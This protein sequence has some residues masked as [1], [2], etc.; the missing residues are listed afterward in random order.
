MA[1]ERQDEWIVVTEDA[2]TIPVIEVLTGR[3]FVTGKSGSG[4]SVLEGTI[5]YTEN[6]RK[7]IED[8]EKGERVLSLNKHDYQNEFRE[9]L[10]TI[11]HESDR[12]LRLT[13]EDGTELVGTE[14]HSFL[15]IE[16]LEIVPIRGDELTVGTWLP[17]ART[18]P[19]IERVSSIDLAEYVSESPDLDIRDHTIR[20]GQKVDDRSIELD[21]DAGRVIGFYLAEG[22]FDSEMTVQISNID[23]SVKAFLGSQGFKV[24]ERTCD[25]AFRPF[26]HFLV[27]EFGRGSAN[28]HLPNWVFQAPNAFKAGLLSGYLD[29]DGSVSNTVT[30]MS[31]SPE[32]VR[33]I[34]ELLRHFGIS[35]TIREQWVL[36]RGEERRFERLSVDAFT[37]ER[38]EDEIDLLVPEKAEN[39][40]EAVESITTGKSYNARDMNPGVGPGLNEATRERAWT[41]RASEHR[42]QAASIHLPTRKQKAGRET[43]NRFVS[44]LKIEGRT[45]RLG[46]SDI[47]WQR[48]VD[49]EELEETRRVYDLDVR[50]ND[51]FIAD[52]VFVHNSN[53]GSVIAEE[54]LENG[55]NLMIIDTEGEYF[56]LKERYELLHVGADDFADV[57]V[58]P[59]HAKKI[60]E[61]ALKRNMPI[62]L[63]V[64]GFYDGADAEALIESVLEHLYRL[65]KDERKPFL[66]MIEEMQEYLPQKGGGTELA[67]LIERIA[68]RGRK[69]GLGLC[70]MSQRPSSV[71]KDFITQ[72]DWM[73][74]HR[75][76]WET[77]INVVRNILG[78]D[79][80]ADIQEFNPGEGILMTDWDDTI[81]T[82]QFKRKRTHDAGATPGL[83]QYERPDLQAVGSE[84]IA[85][86]K[87]QGAT[88]D[89]EP[90]ESPPDV[91]DE[92]VEDFPDVPLTDEQE[93]EEPEDL[94]DP[95]EVEVDD[96]TGEDVLAE[97]R[98]NE[99]LAAEVE[100]LRSILEGVEGNDAAP[101]VYTRPEGMDTSSLEPPTPPRRP[102]NRDGIPGSMVEFCLMLV[103]LAKSAWYRVRLRYHYR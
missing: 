97:R 71:D 61:V 101:T 51:N 24:Y 31:K 68:K 48:I 65:E 81:E 17:L 40:R 8:V 53:T 45:K 87:G 28:K 78:S 96:E 15:T 32:L 99:L 49:I 54:L 88:A 64:S 85:E 102:R 18:L 4:K 84:L 16:D 22:S 46:R 67:A 34:K 86:I 57:Q 63:D 11:E 19:S 100:E 37:L 3:G 72:C 5:V 74:W 20:S 103:Y 62:I 7:P 90:P 2:K 29:G 80:A 69:R 9:V 55:Y 10:A 12:L 52:G 39:L 50:L 82:V 79:R 38:L 23:P 75:L 36:Y 35:S 83:E 89:L 70:G 33:G 1:R 92:P 77:D 25:R 76:T 44:D 13:L 66:V 94:P 21:F 41:T 43:F 59:G 30:V 26:A 73:V 58:S 6:G 47:Q 14:D 60:A 42:T 56:G 27:D 98:R 91:E 93:V 95:T